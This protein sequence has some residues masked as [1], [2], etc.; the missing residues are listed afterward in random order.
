VAVK[1]EKVFCDF[2]GERCGTSK[3]LWWYIRI[4]TSWEVL[5]D[6]LNPYPF[7]GGDFCS[8]ECAIQFL[9]EQLEK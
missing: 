6:Y 8:M 7:E 5:T 3:N 1:E 2:C 4:D 9:E